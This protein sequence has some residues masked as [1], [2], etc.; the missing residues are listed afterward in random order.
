MAEGA[1]Q[2]HRGKPAG[3]EQRITRPCAQK[4]TPRGST[5]G[6]TTRPGPAWIVRHR[7]AQRNS[8]QREG[9]EGDARRSLERAEEVRVVGSNRIEVIFEFR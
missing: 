6:P 5:D 7:E 9:I 8:H 3:S 1:D 2:F 4:M